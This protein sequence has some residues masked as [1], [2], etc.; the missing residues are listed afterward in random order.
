MSADTSRESREWQLGLALQIHDSVFVNQLVSN[1]PS[2]N[3]LD[4]EFRDIQTIYANWLDAG[5][6]YLPL[7]SDSLR[8]DRIARA[9]GSQSGYAASLLH[10]FY[11][12][13]IPPTWRTSTPPAEPR[14]DDQYYNQNS[15]QKS[16]KIKVYPNPSTGQFTY[17]VKGMMEMEKLILMNP[18][19]QVVLNIDHP[20]NNGKLDLGTLAH[21]MYLLWA[22]SMDGT[23][24]TAHI[25][26][27]P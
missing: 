12:I 21:G 18:L 14:S 15:S 7:S 8:V 6:Q 16:G 3:S 1:Y 17:A 4:V 9:E 22:Q 10:L 27:Q 23:V 2:S 13:A 5:P 19:G 25:I 20:Q 26:I 11:G 24:A